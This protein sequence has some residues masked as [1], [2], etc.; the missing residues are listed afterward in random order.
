MAVPPDNYEAFIRAKIKEL[1]AV[2]ASVAADLQ[3][4][5]LKADLTDFKRFRQ[6]ELLTQV[7]AAR[8]ALYAASKEFTDSAIPPSYGRGTDIAAT[9]MKKMGMTVSVDMGNRL[10]TSAVQVMADQMMMDLI[11]GAN[12]QGQFAETYIRR[13]QQKLLTERE[14]NTKIASGVIQGSTRKEVSDSILD[15]MRERLVDGQLVTAGSR[16]YKPDYYAKMVARTRTAE[17]V[18]QGTINAGIEAGMDLFRV[19]IHETACPT[20]VPFQ[21][22][23]YSYSGNDPDFPKLERVPPFHPNCRHKLTPITRKYLEH[24]GQLDAAKAMNDKS[25]VIEGENSFREF[26]ASK[27]PVS[28]K[29]VVVPTPIQLD[30]IPHGQSGAKSFGAKLTAVDGAKPL[31]GSTGAKMFQDSEG[32]KWVVKNYGGGVN[33]AQRAK[34]EYLANRIYQ[35]NN[36]SVPE[37]RLAEVDGVMSVASK[38]IEESNLTT[39][40][41]ADLAKIKEFATFK[42]GFVTDAYLANWD[43]AGLE[44]DNVL[45]VPGSKSKIWRVDQGGALLYRAQGDLKGDLFGMQVLETASLRN[46]SLNPSAATAFSQITDEDL[47]RQIATFKANV[48]KSDIEKAIL[49][50]GFDAETAASLSNIMLARY[51]DLSEQLK[52]LKKI[53][54]ERSI[55]AANLQKAA[56]KSKPGEQRYHRHVNSYG[57]FDELSKDTN[58][59]KGLSEEQ[60]NVIN[61]Y[62]EL[63]YQEMNDVAWKGGVGNAALDAALH[64]D[65]LPGYD[66]FTHREIEKLRASKLAN[67]LEKFRTGEWASVTWSAYSSASIDPLAISK[68]TKTGFR[69]VILNKGRQG[70]YV[71]PMSA[72]KPEREL[73]YGRNSQFRVTGIGEPTSKSSGWTIF[74]EEVDGEI[75]NSQ[76]PPPMI[77]V[78][79]FN[80]VWTNKFHDGMRTD[81]IKIS[82]FVI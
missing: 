82:D 23:V 70:G 52:T 35:L 62:T 73:L 14:L 1:D 30:G 61:D 69:Y 46:S 79:K 4:S 65:V 9:F 12:A 16:R 56:N 29:E 50:A 40:G 75:P 19:T 17:A 6:A 49:D 63:G 77:D 60:K 71:A 18:T 13:T 81:D 25:V 76:S 44:Y 45:L 28:A 10:H 11:G 38:F 53:K 41:A 8:M 68:N 59:E 67:D 58:W 27:F 34:N 42:K 80:T 15:T 26:V 51:D 20:C 24:L 7:K 31:G 3:K 33:G 21:G 39:L 2:Y 54:A 57:T 47:I 64:G 74:L 32:V 22:R 48:R 66:G 78:V 36:V 72:Y 37:A 55:D 5:L 43:V